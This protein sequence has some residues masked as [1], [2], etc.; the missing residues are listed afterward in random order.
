MPD[1]HQIKKWTARL[2]PVVLGLAI[3][4]YLAGWIAA[5]I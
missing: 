4:L 1:S 3:V 2:I 5:G